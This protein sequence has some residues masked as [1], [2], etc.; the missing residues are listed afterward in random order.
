[1][2]PSP[3]RE[4]LAGAVKGARQGDKRLF[5]L[6]LSQRFQHFL[7]VLSGF[8]TCEDLGDF[9]FR[10]DDKGIARG[11]LFSVVFHGRSVLLRYFRAGISQQLEIQPFLCAKILVRLCRIYAHAEDDRIQRLEFREIALEIF[12][13]HRATAREIL[14]VKIEHHP[15][16]AII[17]QA[18][19]VAVAGGE[20]E[21]RRGCSRRRLFLSFSR[22]HDGQCNEAEDC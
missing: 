19:L 18:Y 22:W 15:F 1:M 7:A 16:A 17:F 2:V 20:L 13:L 5:F 3:T 12:R 10:I 6:Q 4:G 14:R 11:E 21:V 9:A 8:N